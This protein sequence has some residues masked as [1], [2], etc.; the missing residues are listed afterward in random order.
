MRGGVVFLS[1]YPQYCCVNGVQSVSTTEL[2]SP[3]PIP[4]ASLLFT[5]CGSSKKNHP[6]EVQESQQGAQT[7]HRKVATDKQYPNRTERLIGRRQRKGDVCVC[8][9][10]K[11]SEG[12]FSLFTQLFVLSVQSIQLF[13]DLLQGIEKGGE[14]LVGTLHIHTLNG[15]LSTP[16]LRHSPLQLQLQKD[17]RILGTAHQVPT[18]QTT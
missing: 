18:Q 5:R 16:H 10:F 9:C 14:I 3:S 7:V 13:L 8:V 15:F 2:S 12:V 17:P 6:C 11:N 1:P 4:G